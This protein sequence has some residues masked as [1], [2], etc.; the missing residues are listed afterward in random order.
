MQTNIGCDKEFAGIRPP[1]MTIKIDK[2]LTKP[3]YAAD[4]AATGL[5]VKQ[6]KEAILNKT[7]G[8]N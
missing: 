1:G 6:A 3:G 8:G 7:I 4:A 2:T 5:V